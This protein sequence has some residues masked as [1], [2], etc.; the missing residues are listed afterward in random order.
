MEK[1]IAV[2]AQI[3]LEQLVMTVK[4]DLR[5]KGKAPLALHGGLF[6]N[7]WFREAF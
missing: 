1:E 3:H 2:A 7:M 5:W 6:E 4:M